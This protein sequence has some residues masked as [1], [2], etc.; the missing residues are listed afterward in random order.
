LAARWYQAG[1]WPFYDEGSSSIRKTRRLDRIVRLLISDKKSCGKDVA[2][3]RRIHL[4]DPKGRH[5]H[6]ITLLVN[7]CTLF[8]HRQDQQFGLF[9][10]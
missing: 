10:V 6:R 9:D 4:P 2:G 1:P 8:A 5:P 7:D 3:S